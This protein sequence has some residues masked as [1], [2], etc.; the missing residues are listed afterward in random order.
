MLPSRT[1]E[2]S[3]LNT[4]FHQSD[5]ELILLYGHRH[6]GMGDLLLEFSSDKEVFSFVCGNV[7]P[8]YELTSFLDTAVQKG[9]LKQGNLTS[10][11]ELWE[12]LFSDSDRQDKKKV[13]LI[14]HVDLSVKVSN[15]LLES[16]ISLKNSE[17]FVQIIMCSDSIGFVENSFVSR[18]GALSLSIDSFLKIYPLNFADLR[19]Y[20]YNSTPED[21]LLIYSVLGG[22]S[23]LWKQFDRNLSFRENV[24]KFLLPEHTFLREEVRLLLLEELRELSVYETL[25]SLMAKGNCK[26]NDLFLR[27]GFVRSKI[28]VY[29]KNLME[30]EYVKKDYSENTP[31]MEQSKKG[32]Y[33]ISH[34]LLRFYYTFLKEYDSFTG[35]Y[36][37]YYRDE[38]ATRLRKYA[39]DSLEEVALWMLRKKEEDG[40]LSFDYTSMGRFVGKAGTIPALAVNDAGEAVV[41]FST[42]LHPIMTYEDY[43]WSLFLCKEAGIRPVFI[44]LIS[45]KGFDDKI[46]LESRIKGTVRPLTL[47]EI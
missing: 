22:Y 15:R 17:Y 7:T 5:N 13:L 36:E 26:L 6:V 3:A 10:F 42:W 8:E 35:T 31:G 44:Y 4:S 40:T 34:P 2:I 39:S 25:L 38:I 37:D 11:E 14:Q 18:A 43:E 23:D 28:S 47:N 20:F 1:A 9:Y 29:L 21:A 27:T 45:D 32:V 19:A 12:K 41:V 33:C 30:L 24:I 16:L 46:L